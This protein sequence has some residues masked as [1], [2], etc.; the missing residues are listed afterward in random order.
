MSFDERTFQTLLSSIDSNHTKIKNIS[1][2][3]NYFRDNYYDK[4]VEIW[5]DQFFLVNLESKMNLIYSAHDV[6]IS[7][8]KNGKFE[9]VKGFGDIFTEIFQ[10]FSKADH[11]DYL[12]ILLKLCDLWEIEMIYA[13]A[14][15]DELRHV[16]KS[17]VLLL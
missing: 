7:S 16:I 4:V 9:Y 3:M 1:R 13:K 6:I 17:K 12:N 8:S 11:I 5:K 10:E 14:F 2:Y 15:M